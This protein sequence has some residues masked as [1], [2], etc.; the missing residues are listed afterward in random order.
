MSGFV[1]HPEI[2]RLNT[3]GTVT[4][5]RIESMRKSYPSDVEFGAVA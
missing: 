2:R 1:E 5:S 3:I 4:K